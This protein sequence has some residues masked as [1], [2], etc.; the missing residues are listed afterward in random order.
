M[1]SQKAALHDGRAWYLWT[2]LILWSLRSLNT[3]SRSRT[4]PC[5]NVMISQCQTVRDHY[6]MA[7]PGIG[8]D[9]DQL[10][11]VS[12]TL[13]LW[14]QA[15]KLKQKWETRDS[16]LLS[17]ISLKYSKVVTLT[18]I[19]DPRSQEVSGGPVT[20]WPVPVP[21]TCVDGWW[22]HERWWIGGSVGVSV[23]VS[24]G[25]AVLWSWSQVTITSLTQDNYSPH[26]FSWWLLVS[27]PLFCFNLIWCFLYMLWQW[28]VG[29][30]TR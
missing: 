3:C 14:L 25:V 15:A 30:G 11:L 22:R 18:L 26:P 16:W 2:A 9:L 17:L 19:T 29:A 1:L 10:F 12:F 24:V 27:I 8:P 21:V 4:R 28:L 13:S 20:Q 7:G 5:Y 23:R 6:F